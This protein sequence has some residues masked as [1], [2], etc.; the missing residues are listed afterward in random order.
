L[1][2]D[3]EESGGGLSRHGRRHTESSLPPRVS[4]R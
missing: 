4:T 2:K 1:V 3:P